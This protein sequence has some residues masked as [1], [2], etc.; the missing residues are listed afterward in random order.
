M[1]GKL[2]YCREFDID[3]PDAL[4]EIYEGLNTYAIRIQVLITGVMIGIHRL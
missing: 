4:E 1:D 3:D 2:S